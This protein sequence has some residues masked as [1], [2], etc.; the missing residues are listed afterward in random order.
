MRKND[1]AGAY[2]KGKKRFF[3]INLVLDVALLAALQMSGLSVEIREWAGGL[4]G[5]RWI[6][7]AVYIT[8]FSAG[9]YVIHFP[10][11]YFLEH[12]WE[13]RFHLSNQKF[14]GWF[15]DDLKKGL[16][17]FIFIFVFIEILYFFLRI[18][19]RAWWIGAGVLW[20]FLAL[21]LARIMPGVIIPLFYKY[22]RIGN[23]E[24]RE[25]ILKL[26]GTCRVPIEDI[27]YVDF[28]SK[29]KKAN[30]FV[31]GLGR[32]RRVVLTDN[33]IEGFTIPEIE[34]VVAHELGHYVGKDTGKMIAVNALVIFAA[35][36]AADR[37]LRV[38]LF[39]AGNLN[40]AD[41]AGLP[42]LALV[43]M[44]LGFL[45]TPLVNAF[46]RFLETRADTFSLKLTGDQ[47]AFIRMMRK[48]G[49]MNLAEFEP[50]RFD[51]IMFYDH[52]PLARRIRLAESFKEK[53][54]E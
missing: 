17:S 24:L 20:L 44:A 22:K 41:I 43:L 1:K 10:L 42:S 50:G 53:R 23:E 21:F 37:I 36:F 5:N 27:Y 48:L 33:L 26:F 40:V 45:T 39:H 30:A 31:T 13:H 38:V 11:S 34:T 29:T 35:F 51:E 54:Q 8:L 7:N 4:S 15:R 19:P 9:A 12:A 52:P 32:R 6:I 46:S 2:Q 47:D 25:R 28:S 3:Y 16:I 14:S 18:F 49:E